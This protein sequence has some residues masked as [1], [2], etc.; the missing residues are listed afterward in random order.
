MLQP[1]HILIVDDSET[2][3]LTLKRH[4]ERDSAY[5]HTF[6]EAET[7]EDGLRLLNERSYDCVLLDFMLPDGNALDFIA[8]ARGAERRLRIPIVIQTGTGSQ[9]DAVSLMKAGA[10]DYL[11]KKEIVG[12]TL[13][14]AVQNAI[15]RVATERVIEQQQEDL[16]RS[17]EE[18]KAARDAAEKARREAE[19]ANAAK[20][21]FLAMLSHELRTPLTPV[22]SMVSATLEEE[23]LPH[24]MRDVFALINRNVRVEAR[25]IDDLLDLAKILNGQFQM[26]R[27]PVDLVACW[28][29]ARELCAPLTESRR[30][31]LKAMLP[32]APVRI[33]GDFARLQQMLW[34]VLKNAV[35]FSQEDGLVEAVIETL[36]DRVRI[37]LRDWGEGIAPERL[38]KIFDVFQRPEGPHR[39]GTLGVGLSIARVIADGHQGKISAW[40]E[41]SGRG[42]VFTIELPINAPARQAP[43]PAA[44]NGADGACKTVLVVDDHEDTLHVLARALR[45][46]GF[47]VSVATTAA[48]AL[49]Q[50]EQQPT[51]LLIC[52][53]GLPDGNGWNVIRSLRE[54]SQVKAIA[55][56]GYGMDT[57]IARS[58]ESGFDGHVTKPIEFPRL[59]RL[60]DALFQGRD[61]YA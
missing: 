25:L 57:D 10:H 15:Y 6:T 31:H 21:E 9:A 61:G 29:A 16:R 43:A 53:I 23:G 45:R 20:D 3:R 27:E 35:E 30:I 28:E 58:K 24:E 14:L 37:S 46:R 33:T 2:D 32:A 52:D 4:L 42:A 36:P 48:G 50:F 59:E 38:P 11:I 56:T 18:V 54:K 51:D 39:F 40:S 19:R 47:A 34:I 12:E 44:S 60:I 8:R 55:V 1:R 26:T 17:L 13:R 7:V 41:G 5:S 22:L 49:A